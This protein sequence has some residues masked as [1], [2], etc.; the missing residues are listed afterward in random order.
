MGFALAVVHFQPVT[1]LHTLLL[2]RV[3]FGKAARP[4]RRSRCRAPGKSLPGCTSL[5]AH[6]PESSGGRGG[7]G[8]RKGGGMAAPQALQQ[9]VLG[10][11]RAVA[12][13]SKQL[14]CLFLAFS[15][16]WLCILFFPPWNDTL[17]VKL[18]RSFLL[19]LRHVLNQ[20]KY[21]QNATER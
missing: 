15:L 7:G 19:C 9:C 6:P 4:S 20:R 16:L 1:L 10:R 14:L 2:S 17:S 13:E 3:A 12:V 21:L 8:S 5:S 18:E 11:R